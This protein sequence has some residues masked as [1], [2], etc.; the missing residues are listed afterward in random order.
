MLKLML[1][2][3]NNKLSRYRSLLFL[4]V[5]IILISPSNF[6]WA[7]DKGTAKDNGQIAQAKITEENEKNKVGITLLP[8]VYYTPETKIAFG[9]GGIFTYRF[10]LFFK[11]ARPS[12]LYLAGIYT[13]MKQYILQLKPEIYLKNNSI[14]LTGNFLVQHFPTNFWGVGANTSDST[15]ENYTPQSYFLEFGYQ[16]K[17]FTKIPVYLGIRYHLEDYRILEKEPGKLLDQHLVPGSEGG[18]LSGPGLIITYDDRDNIF[19]PTEGYYLQTYLFWNNK[20]FGSNF[21]FF[22]CNFD[23]R[24]YLPIADGQILALQ[25]TFAF[26]SGY[27]PFFRLSTLGGDTIL[28]GYYSG[29]Y[30]DKDLLAFQAEY[31]FPVWKR[32]SAVVFGALGNI[33][34]RLDHFTWD[35][36]RYA[37]GF[38]LRFKVIP[39][40]KA[41]IRIDFA[42]GPHTTGIYL[43][44]GEA[45]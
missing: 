2:K 44:A 45:F 11:K 1:D 23:L 4:L 26:N 18:F 6:L 36:L 33:A 16:Q 19:Y 12:T 22:N 29:R 20:V 39:K 37:A 27:V 40:E 14:L 34:D 7:E 30:R 31:R 8:I 41:N 9:V 5:L 43:K 24:D 42:F 21:N 15:K 32:F 25:A 17:I 38:G 13:Q 35:T 28:R 10:G 3:E